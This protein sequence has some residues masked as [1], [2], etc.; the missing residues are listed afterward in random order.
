[1]MHSF[2]SELDRRLEGVKV[3]EGVR[4]SLKEQVVQ[5]G[6]MKPPEEVDASTKDQLEFEIK[7]G[8]VS[9]FRLI[10]FVSAG[11]ALASALSSWLLIG[12][13]PKSSRATKPG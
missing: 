13:L 1:M 10:M 2:G 5:L 3:S 6:A 7:S 11:L 9:S 8:F 4:T 12:A